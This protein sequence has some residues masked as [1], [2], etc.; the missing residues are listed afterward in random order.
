MELHKLQGNP[1]HGDHLRGIAPIYKVSFS[2]EATLVGTGFWVTE[3]GHIV[4]AWHVIADNIGPDGIDTGPIFAMCMSA[5]R[6]HTAR[7]LRKSYKHDDFDL[8]LS[9]TSRAMVTMRQGPG[10]CRSP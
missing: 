4:T 10:H 1:H 6:T 7:A 9:E 3:R 5:D 8:A 2:G